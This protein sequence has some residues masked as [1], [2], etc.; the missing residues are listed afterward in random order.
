MAQATIALSAEQRHGVAKIN[1]RRDAG[2]QVIKVIGPAGCG[3]SVIAARYARQQGARGLAYTGKAASVLRR[4]GVLNAT[5][6][7]SYL[8]GAPMEM[9]LP[10]GTTDFNW[11]LRAV[12][13]PARI[14]V[15]DEYSMVGDDLGGD[16][17]QIGIP[18]I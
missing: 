10:D 6:I 16:L 11:N 8:Y 9:E 13:P 14:L 15:V 5:T 2:Q 1:R 4:R 17:L 7:H 18:I 3:K 12:P